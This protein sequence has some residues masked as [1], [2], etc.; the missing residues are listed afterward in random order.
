MNAS[1]PGPKF[2]AV[3]PDPANTWRLADDLNLGY[4]EAQIKAAM[5]SG[6]ALTVEVLDD[7]ASRRSAIV[8]NG[9]ALS[10]VVLSEGFLP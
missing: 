2:L 5:R 8:L 6:D 1:T 7:D 10:F 9:S 4:L 3:G